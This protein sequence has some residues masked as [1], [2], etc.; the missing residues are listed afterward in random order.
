MTVV[1]RVAAR[2]DP[3]SYIDL[4]VDLPDVGL[5]RIAGITGYSIQAELVWDGT[6][7]APFAPPNL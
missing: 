3:G 5:L 2:D 1:V 4:A 7:W 6:G